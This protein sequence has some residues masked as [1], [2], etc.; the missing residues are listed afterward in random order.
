MSIET[1]AQSSSLWSLLLRFVIN[2]I[3]LFIVIVIL[4]YKNT[5]KE[6]YVFSFF[7]MGI[8]I[9]LICS[10]LE[11]IELQ[12]GMA[13]GL[14]AIFAI[15]R[16]RTINYSVKEMTYIFTIIGISV[17]NS[18]AHIPPPVVGAVIVNS[19]VIGAIYILEMF[20]RK[21]TLNS[22]TIT[23]NKTE[24]L[25]PELHQDLLKDLSAQTGQ[26]VERVKIRKMDLGKKSAELE[27]FF[28]EKINL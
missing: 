5:K 13:L 17:I 11:T 20:F 4:Y 8:M 16:F 22:F 1:L 2:L 6:E 19:V 26:K 25:N 18:Q 12:M 14:F 9:F 23:Y 27:I 24:L 3:V 21:R 28:R 15:L 7:L 10:V